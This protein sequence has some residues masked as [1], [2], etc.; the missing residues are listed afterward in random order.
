[1]RKA[2]ADTSLNHCFQNRFDSIAFR[3]Y[4][5]VFL[6]F[7]GSNNHYIPIGGALDQVNMGGK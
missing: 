2:L 1:M 5:K 7:S 6:H 4:Q 3:L